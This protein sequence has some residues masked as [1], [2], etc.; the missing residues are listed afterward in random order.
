MPYRPGGS[1]SAPVITAIQSNT[2]AQFVLFRA[3]FSA[4]RILTERF[5]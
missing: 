3:L 5:S 4:T 2:H 1:L